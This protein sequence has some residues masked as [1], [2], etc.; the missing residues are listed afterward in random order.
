MA[1][2]LRSPRILAYHNEGIVT[3]TAQIKEFS[4]LP[5]VGFRNA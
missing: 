3:T 1:T 4:L 5:Q 2:K